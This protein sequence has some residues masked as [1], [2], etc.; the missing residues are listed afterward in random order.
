MEEQTVLATLQSMGH[1]YGLID[2]ETHKVL[3]IELVQVKH[4]KYT[5]V[6]LLSCYKIY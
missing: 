4:A 2:L 5:A 1:N 6:H 3:H